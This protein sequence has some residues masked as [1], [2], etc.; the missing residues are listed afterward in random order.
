MKNHL[1]TLILGG[2]IG[3]CI[4][5]TISNSK[6]SKQSSPTELTKQTRKRS[7]LLSTSGGSPIS[8]RLS[9][10]FHS[11][12]G[13]VDQAQGADFSQLADQLSALDE[14]S[15]RRDALLSLLFDRWAEEDPEGALL[16]AGTLRGSA[17]DI[18]YQSALTQL[19]QNDFQKTFDWMNE[20]MTYAQRRQA[21]HWL[22]LGLAKVDPSQAMSEVSKLPEGKI[23]DQGI[24]NVASFWAEEDITAAFNWFE[25]APWSSSMKDVYDSLISSYLKQD[26][27]G[28][29]EFLET[30]PEGIFAR[31]KITLQLVSTLAG[32]DAVKSLEIAD[33]IKDP[34]KQSVAYTT[35]F[36][37]WSAQNPEA[38][39][40]AA[41]KIAS[42]PDADKALQND[43]VRQ[44][45]FAL[46]WEE[47]SRVKEEFANLP[48]DIRGEIVGPFVSEWLLED[49]EA[50]TEWVESLPAESAEH[51]IALNSL[52]MT[53]SQWKPEEA[54]HLAQDLSDQEIR[55]GAIYASLKN[56]Y[57][58][59]PERALEVANDTA[60]I[61]GDIKAALENWV[62]EFGEEQSA[63][64]LPSN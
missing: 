23:K 59:N 47:T 43:V 31:D 61:P 14:D 10:T 24:I 8:H 11:L 42:D 35:V 60:V 56:L 44:S 3:S 39:F 20:N 45:A 48:E 64:Y 15:P 2:V 34:N 12:Y 28:A 19:G 25:G 62:N 40:T 29:L 17:R 21:Q 33:S 54:I 27:D 5:L 1:I 6:T 32:K 18:A 63:L 53:M 51:N 49:R 52:A 7:S 16:Y 37:N 36:E 38:A 4:T 9:K 13:A 41:M 26:P 50:A 22:Y 57:R 58:E 46:L 30:M 55:E